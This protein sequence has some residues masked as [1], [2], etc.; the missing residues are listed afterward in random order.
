MNAIDIIKS[1]KNEGKS[2]RVWYVLREN[3]N[4]TDRGE[5]RNP[6]WTE[7][8][9]PFF[10]EKEEAVTAL[11]DRFNEC[12]PK[13]GEYDEFSLW[14]CDLDMDDL[15]EVDWEGI[16]E[17]MAAFEDE[18]LEEIIH[19]SDTA[20]YDYSKEISYDYPSVDGDYL[21]VWNWERYIGYARNI[22]EIRKGMYGETEEMCCHTDR[23]FCPQVSVLIK[24]QEL[25]GLSKDQEYELLKDRL[26][27]PSEDWRWTR[28]AEGYIRNYLRDMLENIEIEYHSVLVDYAANN[29]TSV[30]VAN[31]FK[32]DEQKLLDSSIL[33]DFQREYDEAPCDPDG[34]NEEQEQN[35]L[36][37]ENKYIELIKE[38]RK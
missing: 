7:R 13:F 12:K 10:L 18:D 21:V 28:Q 17:G 35:L 8:V 3:R 32:V 26:D 30:T 38:L 5:S 9:S 6:N 27:E 37:I 4:E 22:N 14:Y 33:G 36:D 29:A 1:I 16:E 2:L 34:L 23:V 20:V 31:A 24:A 11:E 19:E 25:E 15:E